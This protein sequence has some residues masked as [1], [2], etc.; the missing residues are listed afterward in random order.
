M[1]IC[2]LSIGDATWA[3]GVRFHANLLT[4]LEQYASGAQ[5]CVLTAPGADELV[6]D[7]QCT[8]TRYSLPNRNGLLAQINR[9]ARGVTGYDWLLRHDLSKIPGGVDVIFPAYYRVGKTTAILWWVP[10]FQHVHLPE[11]FT[12]AMI[13]ARYRDLERGIRQATLVVLSS[14][15]A[16]KD[17]STVAPQHAHKA[18]V[19]SFVAFVPASVYD[20]DPNT[21]VTKY[22]LPDK[23]FYLPNQFWKHKNHL[24]VFDALRI[25]KNNGIQPCVVC[26]GSSNDHRH[27]TYFANLMQ[28]VTGW[29]LEEQVKFLGLV[30]HEDVH[31]LIRQCI[32]VLN[33]SLFEGWSTTVEEAK[34]VGKRVLL[35]DL[36]VHREQ[37]P[38]RTMYFDPRNVMDLAGKLQEVWRD[39]SPGPDLVLERKARA[40]LPSRMKAYANTFVSIAREAMDM[41]RS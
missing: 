34:S 9:L 1:R 28:T 4:A 29:N 24:V 35:S 14:R 32:C 30:P 2:I 6:G 3:G 10:D 36:E 11:M 26:T 12:P 22:S 5:V 37:D 40:E 18:R 31:L 17:L 38:P 15:D 19:M 8:F 41:A 16:L 39:T 27:P 13:Q 20:V 21:V 7:S 25:L 23:F 33:P